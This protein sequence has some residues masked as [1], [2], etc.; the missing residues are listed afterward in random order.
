MDVVTDEKQL[1]L[2]R[3]SPRAVEATEAGTVGSDVDNYMKIV[4]GKSWREGGG[5]ERESVFVS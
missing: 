2:A 3:K 4:C 5:G 1:P